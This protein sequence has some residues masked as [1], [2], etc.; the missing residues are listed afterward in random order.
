MGQVHS[1]GLAI[2]PLPSDD[3]SHKL[4]NSFYDYDAHDAY[5]FKATQRRKRNMHKTHKSPA[6]KPSY[7][8]KHSDPNIPTRYVC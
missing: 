4:P 1:N 5:V 6:P 8:R 2:G 3:G 7:Q